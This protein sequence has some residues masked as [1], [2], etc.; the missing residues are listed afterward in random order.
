MFH[1]KCA[2]SPFYAPRIACFH[3]STGSLFKRYT[4]V[5]RTMPV[6]VKESSALACSPVNSNRDTRTTDYLPTFLAWF[7]L[8]TSIVGFTFI[9][10][11][12]SS[13]LFLFFLLLGHS[14]QRCCTS[15]AL[16]HSLG[17]HDLDFTFNF[18]NNQRQFADRLK[19]MVTLSISTGLRRGETFNL[20]WSDI[21]L[22]QKMLG[23]GVNF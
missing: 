22:S 18:F 21:G 17:S 19:P 16:E 12:N 4:S 9:G 10:L 14:R 7:W 6:Y 1:W 23:W 5:C 11:T 13:F 8:G 2:N 20:K 15:Y 3:E